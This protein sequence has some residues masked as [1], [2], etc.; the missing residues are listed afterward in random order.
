MAPRV[1]TR[2]RRPW[3]LGGYQGRNDR[4]TSGGY[5]GRNDRGTCGGYQGRND[6]GTSGGYQ[7]RNDRGTSGGYQGRG[8]QHGAPA[9]ADRPLSFE[10]A[11]AQRAEADT[12]THYSLAQG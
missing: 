1:G 7:G 10:E 9:D 4:G 8:A 2:A 5:Q 3:H 11:E 12:W 6:R